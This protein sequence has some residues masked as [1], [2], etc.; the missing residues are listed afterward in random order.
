MTARQHVKRLESPGHQRF[1]DLGPAALLAVLVMSSVDPMP[2]L[3]PFAA[4]LATQRT[5]KV[6]LQVTGQPADD[7]DFCF[8][9]LRRH[10]LEAELRQFAPCRIS[11]G[12]RGCRIP[13][14]LLGSFGIRL[15]VVETANLL[16]AATHVK[17]PR[18]KSIGATIFTVRGNQ[19][20]TSPI[21]TI[22]L[23][24][25][26]G[27]NGFPAFVLAICLADV[28]RGGGF[29]ALGQACS[30]HQAE[31]PQVSRAPVPPPT[32]SPAPY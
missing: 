7:S 21:R 4:A 17:A 1:L 26:M 14:F 5:G 24:A 12:A 10:K 9:P 6:R 31:K 16:S 11:L 19:N 32:S 22:R 30:P 29:E 25:G 28:S 2:W 15:V 20:F 3:A 27:R 23:P 8:F 13:S 18:H